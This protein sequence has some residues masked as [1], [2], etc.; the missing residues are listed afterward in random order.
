MI[1]NNF[2]LRSVLILFVVSSIFLL[3]NFVSAATYDAT[4]GWNISISN[5]WTDGGANCPIEVDQTIPG[6]IIQG[7]D[8]FI[9]FVSD[10]TFT[11]TVTDNNY[12]ITAFFDPDEE[13]E[14]TVSGGFTLSSSTAGTGQLDISVTEGAVTCDKGMD[15]TL[16]KQGTAPVYDATGDWTF[17][18]SN[19]WAL[20]PPGCDPDDPGTDTVTITQN[21]NDVTLVVHDDDGDQTFNGSVYGNIYILAEVEIEGDE[22]T[23]IIVT[24]TLSNKNSGSGQVMITWTD[25]IVACLSGFDLAF[26][27]QVVQPPVVGDGG[28]GGG[29]FIATAAYGSMMEPHVKILRDFRDHFLLHNSMGKGFVRLYN[30]YSPPMADFIAKHDN[31]RTVVRVTLLPAVGVSWVVLK[32]GFASTMALMLLLLSGFIGIVWVR[33]KYKN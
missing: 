8:S 18:S 13:N 32:I 26:T 6:I 10:G 12:N 16:A 2:K 11:G 9:L 3:A 33:R 7:E 22:T 20:G 14:V 19:P 5:G 23:A 21:G 15:I 27:K 25:G 28:G 30:T 17:T 29:C 24:F 4:G 31:L 1:G